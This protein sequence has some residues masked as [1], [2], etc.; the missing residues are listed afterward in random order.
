M[1][2]SL[3]GVVN[4][5]T[6]QNCGSPVIDWFVGVTNVP[7]GTSCAIVIVVFGRWKLVASCE[8]VEAEAGDDANNPIATG[9][10][11]AKYLE[12]LRMSRRSFFTIVPPFCKSFDT[13][14]YRN[15]NACR[16]HKRAASG[17]VVAAL[18]APSSASFAPAP[19]QCTI[20]RR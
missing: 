12:A 11:A 16:L 15:Q 17:T 6:R 9:A 2:E 3:V 19:Q 4:P 20:G 13:S 8:H 5:A 7:A 14:N 1:C 18:P 10:A